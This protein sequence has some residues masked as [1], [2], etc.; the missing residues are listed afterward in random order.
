MN[1]LLDTCV[2]SEFLKKQPFQKAIDW[3]TTQDEES[4]Y[5]SVLTFGEIRKGVSR[6]PDS[7]RRSELSAWLDSVIERYDA[8]ALPIDKATA[9]SWGDLKS[10]LESKGIVL[11]AIDSLIA[12]TAIEHNLTFVTRNE[13]DFAPTGVKI[14]NLWQ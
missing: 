6:L 9:I 8:R 10:G 13:P 12:A 1:Y 4:L 2:L 7:R 5:V 11:P 3:V 14:L